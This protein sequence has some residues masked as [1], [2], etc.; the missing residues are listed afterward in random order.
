MRGIQDNEKII[1]DG[2]CENK[3]I[4][5]KIKDEWKEKNPNARVIRVKT[6][7]KGLLMYWVV[8]EE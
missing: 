1:G 8:V 4:Y 5:Q 7:T 2:Y 3:E 6:D